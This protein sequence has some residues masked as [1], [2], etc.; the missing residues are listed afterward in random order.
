[1]SYHVSSKRENDEDREKKNKQINSQQHIFVLHRDTFRY[2][3]KGLKILES[4]V[5]QLYI[6]IKPHRTL[7]DSGK[8]K[9]VCDVKMY[10]IQQSNERNSI[11]DSKL[12]YVNF[13]LINIP[14]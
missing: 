10:V 3:S 11:E 7:D 5:L 6:S 12:E 9:S 14:L 1:M 13:N 2:Y 8:K 4:F